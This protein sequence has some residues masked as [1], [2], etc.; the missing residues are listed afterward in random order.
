MVL[1]R[2]KKEKKMAEKWDKVIN[3]KEYNDNLTRIINIARKKNYQLNSD[4][5]RLEKVIGLMTMNR[6]SA[7]KYFCPCK[8]SHPLDAIKDVLCPCPQLDEEVAKDGNCFC[9][10]FFKKI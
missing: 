3:T 7:G 4:Q 8:Q 10:L 9:K 1:V 5:A 6:Q 2:L